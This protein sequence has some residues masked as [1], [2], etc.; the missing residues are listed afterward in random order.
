MAAM[1]ITTAIAV[2][3]VVCAAAA[4]AR[5]LAKMWKAEQAEDLA[6]ARAAGVAPDAQVLTVWFCDCKTWGFF[7]PGRTRVE[8]GVLHT[9]DLCAPYD[10][11]L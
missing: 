11:A 7:T 2:A 5:G 4:V 1:T 8:D 3:V 10:E 6:L 9:P